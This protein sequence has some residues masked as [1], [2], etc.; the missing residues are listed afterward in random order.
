[1][2]DIS[3]TILGFT[4]DAEASSLV[5]REDLDMFRI[6]TDVEHGRMGQ[7]EDMERKQSKVWVAIRNAVQLAKKR[8]EQAAFTTL[9]NQVSMIDSFTQKRI[10]Q[11]VRPS[12]ELGSLPMHLDSYASGL[13]T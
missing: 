1:M 9:K 4:R 13:S 12:S 10:H 5:F 3:A 6:R 8:E 11:Y 7:D 2:S